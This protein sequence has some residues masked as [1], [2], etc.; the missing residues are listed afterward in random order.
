MVSLSTVYEK[1]VLRRC[2]R[3]DFLFLLFPSIDGQRGVNR[4]DEF[5]L[6]FPELSQAE[7]GTSI[8]YLKPSWI[9]FDKVILKEKKYYSPQRKP[10]IEWKCRRNKKRK[11]KRK[12]MSIFRFTRWNKF[13]KMN[14]K[15]HE[16]SQNSSA[17]LE[18][19]TSKKLIWSKCVDSLTHHSVHYNSVAHLLWHCLL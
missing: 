18:L 2:Q 4:S 8:F 7:L 16:P 6:R 1:C 12:K 14:R 5:K 17:R 10:K 19:I 15:G 3:D 13:F 11:M 9:F